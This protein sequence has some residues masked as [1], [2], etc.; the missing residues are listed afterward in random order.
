MRALN[1]SDGR[2]GLTITNDPTYGTISWVWTKEEFENEFSVTI[3]AFDK[4]IY[5]PDRG[6]YL[7]V[8]VNSTQVQRFNDPSEHPAL[9][10]IHTHFDFVLAKVIEYL[11]N[12][13]NP[14]YGLTLAEAKKKKAELMR[15]AVIG[16]FEGNYSLDQQT[17]LNSLA[18]L[19]STPTAV[20]L[21]IA[22]V[23]EWIKTV[24]YHFFIT[25]NTINA[26]SNAAEFEAAVW[27]FSQ[28]DATK[29]TH[30]IQSIYTA[31]YLSE[32]S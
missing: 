17:L 29:P 22:E 24:M 7:I 3:D 8:A 18:Q 26:A 9:N 11:E 6:E 1:Y 30:T 4:V 13:D 21:D 19:P 5:E 28:Y 16:Y 32:Q 25:L 31:V 14:Y 12:A 20:K 15:F 23:F 2:V 27:D 10:L